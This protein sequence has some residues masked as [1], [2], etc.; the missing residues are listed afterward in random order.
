MNV[1]EKSLELNTF[2]L[3]R[4]FFKAISEDQN[5]EVIQLHLK[6]RYI[7]EMPC[8]VAVIKDL[9]INSVIEVCLLWSEEQFQFYLSQ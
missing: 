9:E 8:C 3:P 4:K 6:G 5:W 1:K 2:A 7:H